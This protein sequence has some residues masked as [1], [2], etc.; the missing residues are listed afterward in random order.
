MTMVISLLVMQVKY[1]IMDKKIWKA[2]VQGKASINNLSMNFKHKFPFF[3]LC[4]VNANIVYL[5]LD[6]YNLD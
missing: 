4:S 2:K 1:N 6:R 3:L 5:P